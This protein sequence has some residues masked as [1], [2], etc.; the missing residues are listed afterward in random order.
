MGV[1]G[2][3]NTRKGN[4]FFCLRRHETSLA[5][6]MGSRALILQDQGKYR[7]A[8]AMYRRALS[9]GRDED[10]VGMWQ[11]TPLLGLATLVAP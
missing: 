9:I 10:P 4:G 3:L 2:L 6:A 11:A 8:E 7:K 5:E 1:C